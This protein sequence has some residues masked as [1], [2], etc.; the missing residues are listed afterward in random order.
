MTSKNQE[1]IAIFQTYTNKLTQSDEADACAVVR[2]VIEELQKFIDVDKPAP[3]YDWEGLRKELEGLDLKFTTS[4]V[5]VDKPL[6]SIHPLATIILDRELQE[7]AK[8]TL[9]YL[10]RAYW[11]V[12][13]NFMKLQELMR[14]FYTPTHE[15]K[16]AFMAAEDDVARM[17]TIRVSHIGTMI[18]DAPKIKDH[19]LYEA[20]HK[21]HRSV[22]VAFDSLRA[23]EDNFIKSVLN[24][25]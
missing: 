23:T 11:K 8:P 1:L 13:R 5:D 19:T 20:I 14:I 25:F 6:R 7:T 18:T 12:Y 24:H 10:E 2:E 22:V 16:T 4:I 21:A 3:K 9:E 17:K 15:Q